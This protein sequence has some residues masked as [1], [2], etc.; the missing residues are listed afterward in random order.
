[1]KDEADSA[2]A[3]E[4]LKEPLPK[5]EEILSAGGWEERIAKARARRE[6]A[7]ARQEKPAGDKSGTPVE[8]TAG[9]RKVPASANW[10]DRMAKAQEHRDQVL[11]KRA[12][13][14]RPSAE[15]IPGGTPSLY[16]DM[17]HVAVTGAVAEVAVKVP[18]EVAAEPLVLARVEKP[19]SRITAAALVVTPIAPPEEKRK[20]RFGAVSVAAG[21]LLALG[22]GLVLPNPFRREVV[23]AQPPAVVPEAEVP[24]VASVEV[25]AL[26]VVIS[27]PPAQQSAALTEQ[28]LPDVAD[29]VAV[30]QNTNPDLSSGAGV[31]WPVGQAGTTARVTGVAFVARPELATV[32]VVVTTSYIAPPQVPDQVVEVAVVTPEVSVPQAAPEFAVF[33]AAPRVPAPVAIPLPA[34]VLATYRQTTFDGARSTQLQLPPGMP[35]VSHRLPGAFENTSPGAVTPESFQTYFAELTTCMKVADVILADLKIHTLRLFN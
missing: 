10:T 35:V 23:V 9:S 3:T 13:D 11:A 22:I 20:K 25:A 28:T 5:L 15:Q 17:V 21:I 24:S 6:E 12:S 18:V 2:A 27:E 4:E 26:P 30:L 33:I 8:K 19:K 14:G 31:I 32:P 34:P 7:L 16:K 29:V 1:M